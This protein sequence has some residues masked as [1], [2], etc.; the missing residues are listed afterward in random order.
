MSYMQ[1][2]IDNLR[3]EAGQYKRIIAEMKDDER[4][5]LATIRSSAEEIARLKV[6][7]EMMRQLQAIPANFI[8]V[9]VDQY[10][11]DVKKVARVFLDACHDQQRNWIESQL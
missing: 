2:T 11:R 10:T 5:N 3:A 7:L 9:H 1:S 8:V 6:E 4:Q